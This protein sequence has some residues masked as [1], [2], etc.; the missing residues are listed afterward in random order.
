[1]EDERGGM[2]E[3]EGER[4]WVAQQQ[5]E[6]DKEVALKIRSV[7][8]KNYALPAMLESERAQFFKATDLTG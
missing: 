2:G 8:L 6:A 7:A 5:E 1:M 4:Q 3:G